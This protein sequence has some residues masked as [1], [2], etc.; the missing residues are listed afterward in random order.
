MPA[1][2]EAVLRCLREER[3]VL[4]AE[5][6]AGRVR[7]TPLGRRSLVSC[8][9]EPRDHEGV[10][11]RPVDDVLTSSFFLD[12]GVGVITDALY[13]GSVTASPEWFVAREAAALD[14]GL[15]STS[16]GE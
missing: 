12:T 11:P 3:D 8:T 6:L 4:A 15:V 9:F 5:R 1:T 10:L 13:E 14:P 16:E 2:D 7:E